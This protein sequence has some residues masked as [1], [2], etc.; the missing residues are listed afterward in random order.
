MLCCH[1]VRFRCLP[2]RLREE[3]PFGLELG[4]TLRH[5]LLSSLQPSPSDRSSPH[6]PSH[7]RSTRLRALRALALVLARPHTVHRIL[8]EHDAHPHTAPLWPS[9]VAVLADS[10]FEGE[11]ELR[12]RACVTVMNQL[13]E[14]PSDAPTEASLRLQRAWQAKASLASL[15]AAFNSDPKAAVE[16]WKIDGTL[17]PK[18]E[19]ESDDTD[20]GDQGEA[21][22]KILFSLPGASP[23]ARQPAAILSH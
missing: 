15:A 6:P 20:A 5:L 13:D 7:H 2:V 18:E 1:I 3:E 16:A 12:L 4:L 22:G 11:A 14:Q 8:I 9:L 10:S 19:S 23:Q 17:S 21:L